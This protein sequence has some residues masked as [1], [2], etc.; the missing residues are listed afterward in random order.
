MSKIILANQLNRLKPAV[1]AIQGP[2]RYIRF[3]ETNESAAI[4]DYLSERA[5]AQELPLAQLLRARNHAFRK[6]Y[7]E[8]M[9]QLNARNHSLHWWSM[10]FT[11]KNPVASTLCRDTAN[12]LLI[13]SLAR[14]STVPL[15][16][17]TDS[18]DLI[19]QV[20]DWCKRESIDLVDAVETHRTWK[21]RVKE[22]TP[23]SILY[24]AAITWWVW[25]QVRGVKAPDRPGAD[26]TVVTSL[27]HT[28]S[29]ATPGDYK[30]SYFGRLV[31]AL[32]EA[33]ERA[34]VVGLLHEGWREQLAKLKASDW[35]IPVVPVE[36]YLTLRDLLAC[37]FRSVLRV[38]RA[39]AVKGPVEIEGVDLG[40][41]IRRSIRHSNWS[42][43]YFMSLR[44]YYSAKNLCRSIH[45]ARWLYPYENRSWE[46]MLLLGINDAG[47][48]DGVTGD[49]SRGT[50]TVG[51][52]HACVTQSH[53]NF[54]LGAE[55][56]GITPLPD[57]ILT[58]GK[59]V[60]DWLAKDGNYPAGRVMD[61]CAVRQNPPSEG[62][63]KP[64]RQSVTN[65]LVTL[66]TSMEEYINC[67]TFLEK[68]FSGDDR[69]SLSI[70][71]HPVRPL[72]PA[73]RLAPLTK[74]DFFTES[75]GTLADDLEWADVVL[76]ASTTVGVEAVSQG[77]PTIYLD[78]GD[79]LDTDPMFGWD[80]FK[81]S[82]AE[83]EKL[84]ET[85][86]YIEAIPEERFANLQRQGQRY[87]ADY[88][89]P[90]TAEG[91]QRFQEA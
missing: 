33:P 16:V 42:G 39:G 56:T 65:V 88:L 17:V 86:Q 28:R 87:V 52:Q 59:V 44:I 53:T 75:T 30:D 84:I 73:L 48:N 41:L 7:I 25:F 80:E 89:T 61:A 23:V 64:R 19:C 62:L 13:V 85:I 46:K 1:G 51:Y 11:N 50:R 47:I 60:K 70:R 8:F 63:P 20:K 31:E 2:V 68:A 18:F 29:V 14:D 57:V 34:M 37:G 24:Y 21:D 27:F 83:P 49:G 82:V 10:A 12:F 69:Y 6:A 91:L 45:V 55:E 54:I 77:I 90:V 58:T 36:R 26:W 74:K 5:G 32:K 81:W 79:I 78:L 71:P 72:E 66:A 4:R 38:F 9:A 22:F 40:C 3:L 67:L 43:S 15:I 35:G 76:Y